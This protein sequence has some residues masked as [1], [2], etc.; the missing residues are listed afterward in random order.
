M[1]DPLLASAFAMMLASP[2]L[3]ADPWGL[4]NEKVAT[5]PAKVVD[6][7]CAVG[8]VS[9]PADCGGGKRQLGLLTAEGKL[10]PAVKGSV[11][12]AGPAADL[13]P[14]C[15]KTIFVDGLLVENPA[16]TMFFVQN[17]REREN[18]PWKPTEAFR[19][20][21]SAR[22]GD[23]DDWV[24]KDPQAKAIIAADGV[25]GIKGLK[26][27]SPDVTNPELKAP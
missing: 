11:D 22:N 13:A 6:L 20:Q 9:C 25:F 16:M 5:F 2:C 17:L 4:A 7:L 14:F 19:T 18:Q 8:G 27:K 24:R 10:Y 21:W 1:R 15:G 3:A 23:P 26:S 12:F